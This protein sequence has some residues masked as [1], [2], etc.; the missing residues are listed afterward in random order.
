MHHIYTI[1]SFNLCSLFCHIRAMS[2]A[3]SK[4]N[5]RDYFHYIDEYEVKLQRSC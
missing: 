3:V 5:V 1:L 2:A 4:E